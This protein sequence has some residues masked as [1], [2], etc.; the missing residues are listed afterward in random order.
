MNTHDNTE[1]WMH[2]V[3]A[4]YFDMCLNP[5]ADRIRLADCIAK[6]APAKTPQASIWR[7]VSVRPTAEDA[8]ST[9]HVQCHWQDGDITQAYWSN[10]TMHP[11]I[12]HWTRTADL[13]ALAPLTVEKT[14]EERDAEWIKA[15][16]PKDLSWGY[17]DLSLAIAYG[18]ST[19]TAA[20]ETSK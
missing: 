14:Q 10:E 20:K 7:P 1:Q 9:G 18:R 12:T 11:R 5:L 15:K 16:F 17:E 3:A 6:H 19:A 8:N 13:L 4:E 2:D